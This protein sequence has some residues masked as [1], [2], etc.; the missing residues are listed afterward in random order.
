MP[1]NFFH[2]ISMNNQNYCIMR[3]IVTMFLLFVPDLDPM[4]ILLVFFKY[5]IIILK[6]N[7][8]NN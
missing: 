6:P 1:L 2:I 5:Y 4:I 7:Q 3:T 8:L